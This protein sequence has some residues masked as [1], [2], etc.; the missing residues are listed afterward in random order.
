MDEFKL[1]LAHLHHC[2]GITW[3]MIYQFLRED[4]ELTNLYTL[5]SH[6]YLKY[7]SPSCLNTFQEDLHSQ[8][9][10]DEIRQYEINEIHIITLFDEIYPQML[11]ETYQPPWI[12][13]GKGNINLLKVEPKL[14]VVG[15][16][17]AT[18]YGKKSIHFL[19]PKI[20]KKGVIIVSG[21]AAG[22]DAL[23]H[24]TAIK[25]G[26]STIAVIAG[27]LFHIYPKSNLSLALHMMRHQLV[28]SEFPPN[29]KPTRWQFPM[30]NRIIS[31]LSNGTLIIEAKQKSGSLITANYAVHEGREVFALPGSIF[32]SNSTGTNELIQ[33]GAKLVKS[34]EDILEELF[35]RRG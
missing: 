20:L 17:Q 26:G 4:P 31:G 28:I 2:R 22:V 9:I 15:S 11:K 10:Y 35:F 27:G 18:E 19:F 1:K 32:N 34:D 3:K 29:S 8:T 5:S 30:R 16:R 14:A 24:E 7:L 6:K 13:Y 23:A 21:L 12:L 33:Q 25:L